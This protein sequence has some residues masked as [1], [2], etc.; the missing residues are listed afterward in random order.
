MFTCPVAGTYMFVVDV[1]LN[2]YTRLLLK[3]NKTTVAYLFRDGSYS[4]APLVQSSKTILQKLKQGD[5]VKV[6]FENNN[7]F[8]N[9]H[10]FSTFTGTFFY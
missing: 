6:T 8:L 3:S 4:K 2:K 5:H 1:L 9:G 10:L 7:G